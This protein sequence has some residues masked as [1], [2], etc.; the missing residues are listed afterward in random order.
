VERRRTE[1]GNTSDWEWRRK[2]TAAQGARQGNETRQGEASPPGETHPTNGC[3]LWS[4]LR[5]P[6][7]PSSTKEAPSVGVLNADATWGCS[8]EPVKNPPPISVPPQYL[9][10]W[11]LVEGWCDSTVGC[12]LCWIWIT[13]RNSPILGSAQTHP[14]PTP[15]P[16]PTTATT[17][18]ITGRYPGT[19]DANQW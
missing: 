7:G 1:Q 9:Q 19:L 10:V 5:S 16:T 12:R 6:S 13:I 15:T 11:W 18:S 8:S 14:T 2:S 17:H 3:P 4:W